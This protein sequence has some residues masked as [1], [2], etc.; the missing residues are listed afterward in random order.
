[1]GR[2]NNLSAYWPSYRKWNTS[3]TKF[4]ISIAI[5]SSGA[6]FPI[7]KKISYL[8]VSK[9]PAVLGGY[10]LGLPLPLFGCPSSSSGCFVFLWLFKAG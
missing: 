3:S 6:L 7:V 10:F 9:S 2:E 8:V 1:L 4:L 5:P